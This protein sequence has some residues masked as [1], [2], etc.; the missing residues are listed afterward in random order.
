MMRPRVTSRIPEEVKMEPRNNGEKRLPRHCVLMKVGSHGD[1]SFDAILD[2]KAK[3]AAKVGYM[4]WGYSGTLL[5]ARRVREYL[6]SVAEPGLAPQLLLIETSSPFFNSPHQSAVFSLDRALW[7][8]LPSGVGTRG[9]DKA[10]ICASLRRTSFDLDLSLY[11][12][13]IGPSQG[14]LVS[15]YLKS[16]TDKVCAALSDQGRAE[17]PTLVRVSWVAEILAPYSVYLK[18]RPPEQMTLLS[19]PVDDNLGV[20]SGSRKA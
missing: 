15:S 18:T 12:V 14:R 13:A 1:E 5:D 4:L 11:Q 19:P 17:S 3:E 20:F 6:G 8:H 10:I 16:R 9:C 7:F 2:R